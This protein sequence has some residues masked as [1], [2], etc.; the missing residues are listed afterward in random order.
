MG[1]HIQWISGVI[2]A[3]ENLHEFGDDY[4]LACFVQIVGTTAHIVGMSG[5]L[6]LADTRLAVEEFRRMGLTAIE[7]ERVKDGVTSFRK[8]KI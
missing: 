4:E 7:F 6:T 5:R 8:I 1:V 3:G 2:R